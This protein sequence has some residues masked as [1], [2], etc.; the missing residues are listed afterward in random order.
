MQTEKQVDLKY[1]EINKS[2]AGNHG[3]YLN[4]SLCDVTLLYELKTHNYPGAVIKYTKP[5]INVSADTISGYDYIIID[6]AYD[7]TKQLAP[8]YSDKLMNVYKK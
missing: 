5:L 6:K 8:L 3:Y 4:C 7:E 1:S 2:I